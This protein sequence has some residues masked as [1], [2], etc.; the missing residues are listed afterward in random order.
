[1]RLIAAIA[2]L[3]VGTPA[4]AWPPDPCSLVSTVGQVLGR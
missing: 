2:I 1:M 4:L 3:L